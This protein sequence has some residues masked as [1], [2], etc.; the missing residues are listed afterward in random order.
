[1]QSAAEITCLN[2]GYGCRFYDAN[3]A[4]HKIDYFWFW[5]FAKNRFI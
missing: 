4:F 2:E 1:M 5:S 3:S